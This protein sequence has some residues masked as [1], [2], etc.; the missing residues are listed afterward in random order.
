ME[1]RPRRDRIITIEHKDFVFMVV[2]ATL[3]ISF[4]VWNRFI[5]VRLPKDL[6]PI[7]LL[8][9]HPLQVSGDP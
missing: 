6:F 8:S 9:S 3:I 5:R 4:I 7:D 2:F 1:T